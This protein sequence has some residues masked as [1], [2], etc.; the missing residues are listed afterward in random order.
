MK[1][2]FD[3]SRIS[4]P[5]RTGT[6]NYSFYLAQALAA[7]DRENL[8]TL[9]F[10]EV[11]GQEEFE[12]IIRKNP[13]FRIKV[14]PWP[15]LWTQGGLAWECLRYPLD[16]LFVPAHT[17]PVIRRP[18][19]KSVVTIHDLGFEYLPEYY[20]FPQKL[21]L[22]KATKFAARYATHLIAVSRATKKDLTL[23]FKVPEEKIAVVYEGVDQNKF[24][25]PGADQSARG[26]SKFKTEE[27]R[28]KY[29]IRGDYILFVG[30]IQ[31]RKNLRRLIEAFSRITQGLELVIAGRPG[32]MFEGIYAAPREFGV[33]D[34]VKFLGHIEDEDLAPLYRGAICFALPSLYE[35]FGLPVLE[36]MAS[37]TPVVTSSVSALPEVG[38][39]AA[40]YVDPYR[41]S[42]IAEGLIRVIGGGKSFRRSLVHKGLAQ[43]ARFSWEKAAR[44]TL[45]V[46]E[47]V[48]GMDE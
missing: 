27:V 29:N 17:L 30:T 10:R 41:V 35:G 37:G 15:R 14:I 2:G 26:G 20:R 24:N 16:L 44:E 43:A 25:P 12:K 42:S 32:W 8:Y 7:V 47:K 46:F 36:A 9:Y 4:T 28:R 18:S 13:N 23:R 22:D 5:Q 34:R 1:I 19:L 45:K 11:P 6:E 39:G 3:A 33:E 31:P 48:V 21:Y 40:V 38:G